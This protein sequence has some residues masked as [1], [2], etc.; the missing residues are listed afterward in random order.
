MLDPGVETSVAITVTADKPGL[1]WGELLVHVDDGGG[2]LVIR[3]AARSAGAGESDG[4]VPVPELHAR[5]SA[6]R[7]PEV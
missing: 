2:P 1:I 4:R 6:S 7:P 5:G 3:L